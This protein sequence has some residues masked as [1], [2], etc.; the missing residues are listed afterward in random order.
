LTIAFINIQKSI[1]E[2]QQS[3]AC[4]GTASSPGPT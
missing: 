1:E 2:G 3:A 4:V